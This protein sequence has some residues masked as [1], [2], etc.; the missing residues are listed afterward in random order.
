[1][2]VDVDA[3]ATMILLT[4][5][6]MGFSLAAACGLRAFLPLFVAGLLAHEGYVQLAP[7]F[8]WLATT[9]ALIV[10]GAAVLFE[11]AGDKVPVL[12]HALDAA[13]VVVKPTAATLLAASLLVHVDPATRTVLALIAGGATAGGVHL[14]KA[15]AR[16]A[17]TLFTAGVGNPLL[18][19]AEDVAAIVVIA[20]AVLVPLAGAAIALALIALA[21]G[22]LRRR[23]ARRSA[24]AA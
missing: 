20:V 5:L 24:V 7:S 8:A 19:V 12:D 1:M 6:A 22:W 21:I 16:L 4:E 9:P 23:R 11:V 3:R 17:S 15:K 2:V 13:G 18:S 14:V 10:F